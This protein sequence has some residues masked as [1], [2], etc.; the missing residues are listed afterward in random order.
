MI[1]KGI[2]DTKAYKDSLP[3]PKLPQFCHSCFQAILH[4]HCGEAGCCWCARC[5]NKAV[6]K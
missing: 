2:E 6:K 5:G 1:D 3:A 4:W